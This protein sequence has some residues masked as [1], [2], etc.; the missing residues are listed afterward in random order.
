[1]GELECAEKVEAWPQPSSVGEAAINSGSGPLLVAYATGDDKFAVI[2]IHR[3]HYLVY[4]LPNDEA[5]QGHPLYGKGLSYYSVHRVRH[6]KL[7][8]QLE[9][10]N[11]VHPRHDRAQFLAGKEH[12]IIT[13]QDATLELVI[14]NKSA[15]DLKVHVFDDATQAA[16]A[17]GTRLS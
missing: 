14:T 5:L 13:F 1:M 6:S 10:R 3:Y 2:E 8:D 4:G 12:Y 17:F 7:I 11:A 15:A 16:T 9:V